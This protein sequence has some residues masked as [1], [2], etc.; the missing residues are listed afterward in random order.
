MTQRLTT[1]PQRTVDFLMPSP[2][3]ILKQAAI[4]TASRLGPHRW[5][6]RAPRLWVLMYHRVLPRERAL[7]EGEEPG[8]YVTPETFANHLRWLRECFEIVRLQDWINNVNAGNM[9]P[10][11][12]CAVTFDDGWY[13]NYQYALPLLQETQTPA[14]LF[15]VSHLLGSHK[16]FWPNRLS[17]LL[18][19]YPDPAR[20]AP[21]FAW[22]REL[23]MNLPEGLE[24][25][26]LHADARAELIKQCKQLSDATLQQYLDAIEQNHPLATENQAPL[27][28]WPQLQAMVDSGLVD[29]GSHTCH[30]YRLRPE[31]PAEVAAA[32]IRASKIRLQ[33]ELNQPVSLFCYP[34][35]DYTAAAASLVKREYQAAV[36]TQRGINTADTPH[37]R[38][39]R[40]GLHEDVS[41]S[42]EGFMA[43]LSG[44]I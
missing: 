43:R 18:D 17:R 13:D 39:R 28:S 10:A 8:M 4:T 35:G 30:H 14:T 21:E 40:I 36:T 11:R 32:E 9:V 27:M 15:A 29:V 1:F 37:N 44:W 34:N 38:L 5:H 23:A 41:A 31:L 7:A 26:L 12:A 42:Y 19:Q 2:R 25:A 16:P 33:Q 20:T 24:A 6:S 22:L 3:K